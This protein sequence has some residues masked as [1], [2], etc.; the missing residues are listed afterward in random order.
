MLDLRRLR[1]FREV[2][3][4]GSFSA[5]AD[6]LSFTQPSISRQIAMLE[7]EVGAQ[8]LERDPRRVRLTQAGELLIEHAEAVL[9]RLDAAHAQLDALTGLESGRLRMSAFAS[10]NAWLVPEALRRFAARHPGV[11]LS[12]ARVD[13][14]TE[15]VALRSGDVD[16]ALI[17]TLD[18]DTPQCREAIETIRI[19]E[20]EY[21]LALP[22]EHRLADREHVAFKELAHETWIE[23]A[24][25]DCLGDVTE[26]STLIGAEPRIGFHCD[27]WTGKQALVAAGVGI[28][29]C[30]RLAMGDVRAD[31][32][33]RRLPRALAPR[34]V[35]AAVPNGYRAPAVDEMLTCL[36]EVA[37]TTWAAP[38][39]ASHSS[40]DGP[41]SV[42]SG[43]GS[44]APAS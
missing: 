14:G 24:H 8:L 25:P 31:V 44:A 15:C 37:A 4:R 9:A 20:D 41:A 6:A 2:A 13:P 34:T 7:S 19:L 1:A 3:R 33:V 12:L 38:Y 5:A 29:L 11:E 17:T 42:A 27:D 35:Y 26:L 36:E 30:P 28:M 22:R 40:N 43:P 21:Y 23:G 18:V 10:A 32:V 16:L 39:A